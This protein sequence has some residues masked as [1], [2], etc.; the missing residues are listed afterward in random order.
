KILWGGSRGR[1]D[2]CLVCSEVHFVTQRDRRNAPGE[3]GWRQANHSTVCRCRHERRA[4]Y[5]RDSAHVINNKARDGNV[6]S[7][8]FPLIARERLNGGSKAQ[9]GQRYTIGGVKHFGRPKRQ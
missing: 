6:V 3:I 7:K 4:T 9:I 2:L 8:Q 1:S 5:R